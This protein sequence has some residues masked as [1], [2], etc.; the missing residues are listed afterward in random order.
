MRAPAPDLDAATRAKPIHSAARS[1]LG[2]VYMPILQAGHLHRQRCL[3][4][5]APSNRRGRTGE[6]A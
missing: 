5:Q 3:D 1:R 4:R 2:A 6:D